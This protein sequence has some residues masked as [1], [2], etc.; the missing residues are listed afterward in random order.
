VILDA[1]TVDRDVALTADV[2]IVGSGAGGAMVAR[3]VAAAG[4][5]V[6]VVEEG[7]YV[8]PQEFT[9]R[10][11][12]MLE[13][14]YAERG[15]STTLDSTVVVALGRVVGGSTVP[16]LCVCTRPPRAVLQHWARAFGLASLRPAE[17]EPYF[18]LAEARA[19]VA[20]MTTADINPNNAKL[21]AGAERLGWRW[22]L[23]SHNRIQCLG[24]GFCTLGCTY[25]RKADALTV[26]L[27]AALEHGAVV[28][29][30]CRVDRIDVRDGVVGGVQGRFVSAASDT[31]FRLTV[32]APTV[33]L[34]A[35]AIGSPALWLR[36][37]LPNRAQQVGRHLRLHPQ[38]VMAGE[39][40]DDVGVWD[41]I[42]QSVVVE[43][44]IDLDSADAGG[45]WLNAFT[46]HPILAA[47]L[48]PGIGPAYHDLL[49]AYR[50]LALASVTLNER[51][52]GR[53]DVDASGRASITYHL[54]DEDRLDLLNGIRRTADL[55]FAGG[56]ERVLL[57]FNDLV[58]LT[59]RGDHRP[60][61]DYPFRA[62]DPLL[63]SYHPQG[64]LRMGSD[65]ARNV[66]GEYGAAHEVR[67][68]YVA[69]AS[70]FPTSTAAPPQLAV[71]A[72]AL[73]TA[74]RILGT[75]PARPAARPA[76][77]PT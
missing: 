15:A 67:G 40:P 39:F 57:P 50:R 22:R 5:S 56:A 34:A 66:V 42:P 48:L 63:L 23:L 65:P 3:E 16:G 17:V 59:K 28:V 71:M 64:T 70:V 73:R 55:Y 72:F 60:L 52:T 44:F 27:R 74:S 9:Q 4:R 19:S 30:R 18:R 6:V 75:A 33:V 10:E 24:C 68:L 54:G 32:R 49:G 38:V 77:P 2:C 21:Q 47:S 41:G 1:A 12:Q 62:N 35:G 7:A 53:V 36:S 31:A 25:D 61:D 51:S 26:H 11:E 8:R 43:E 58:E 20:P 14:L 29:P 37:Q 13:R 76:A 45:F 69:D 46:A